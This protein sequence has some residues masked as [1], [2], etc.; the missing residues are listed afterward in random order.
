VDRQLAQVGDA[1]ARLAPCGQGP[2]PRHAGE[3]EPWTACAV[4]RTG[5]RLERPRNEH[6]VGRALRAPVRVCAGART[7]QRAVHV[8]AP[9]VQA[10]QPWAW[11]LVALPKERL[12]QRARARQRRPPRQLVPHRLCTQG[13]VAQ[14]R[15]RGAHHGRRRHRHRDYS[16][17][18][19]CTHECRRRCVVCGRVSTLDRAVL[20]LVLDR[21]IF[22]RVILDRVILDRVIFHRVILDR[23]WCDRRRGPIFFIFGHMR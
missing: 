16:G 22:D 5:V 9:R 8:P 19:T 14:S 17:T 6:V 15:C 23:G 2:R 18:H 3:P 13:V 10:D 1:C 21:V 11:D 7:R 20:F 12:A 4:G